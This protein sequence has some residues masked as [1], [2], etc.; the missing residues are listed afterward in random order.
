MYS[1]IAPHKDTLN[2][3]KNCSAEKANI[4]SW[5]QNQNKK[6]LIGYPES[7]II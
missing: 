5:Q 7:L 3:T 6:E 4:V 2:V 1:H